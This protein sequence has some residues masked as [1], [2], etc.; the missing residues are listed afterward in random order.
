M[1]SSKTE[2]IIITVDGDVFHVSLCH[3]LNSFFDVLDT[4][5]F[6]H[7]LGG[8]VGV[9]TSSVPVSLQWLRV[10][11]DLDAPFFA[12]AEEQE[13]CHCQVISH[14]NSEAGSDLELPLGR[15]NF[16]VDTGDL[17][18][19]VEAG[20]VVSLDGIT[21][22]DLAGTC[23]SS[24]AV[25]AHCALDGNQFLTEEAF[26]LTDTAVVWTLRTWETSLGPSIRST[27]VV[28]EGVFLLDTEPRLVVGASIHSL[29]A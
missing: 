21:G 20:S 19:S 9:A 5:F 23:I 25:S 28:E 1:S 27:I 13:S 8:V 22:E 6:S 4:T 17:D 24:N 2:V 18:T 16:S 14:L 11:R 29:L 26:L 15:H 10:E 7:E 12:D 3:L